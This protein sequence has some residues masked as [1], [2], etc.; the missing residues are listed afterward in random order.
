MIVQMVR[1]TPIF[2]WSVC[3]DWC[4]WLREVAPSASS[5]IMTLTSTEENTGM[6]LAINSLLSGYEAT[7]LINGSA[8]GHLSSALWIACK[9]PQL[10]WGCVL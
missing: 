8:Q 1:T 3:A 9:M 10:S 4:V 2:F 6:N 5:N 7:E